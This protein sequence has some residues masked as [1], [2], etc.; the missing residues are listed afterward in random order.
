MKYLIENYKDIPAVTIQQGNAEIKI[1]NGEAVCA[2]D[3]QK[4]IAVSLGG[5]PAVT[6]KSKEKEVKQ[7]D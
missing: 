1:I 5:V 2:T 4:S 7:N 6:V 3:E